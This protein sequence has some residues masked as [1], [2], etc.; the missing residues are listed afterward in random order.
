MKADQRNL[1][2]TFPQF[3]VEFSCDLGAHILGGNG[4]M[5]VLKCEPV[6]IC[7]LL[8]FRRCVNCGKWQEAI[9]GTAFVPP[10]QSLSYRSA[11]PLPQ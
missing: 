5:F 1:V 10:D 2:C 4:A 9:L 7:V 3:N 8:K 11:T 6:Q